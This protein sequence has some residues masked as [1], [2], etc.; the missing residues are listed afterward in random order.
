MQKSAARLL[1]VCLIAS[2]LVLFGCAKPEQQPENRPESE[3][4]PEQLNPQLAAPQ[5]SPTEKI[6]QPPPKPEEVSEALKRVFNDVV[7][8]DT[9]RSP[10]FVAGD[11]NADGSEDLAIVVK[12]ADTEMAILAINDELANWLIREP[13][14]VI[15]ARALQDVR[16]NEIHSKPDPIRKGDEMIVIIPSSRERPGYS[17]RR[18]NSANTGRQNRADLLDR[19]AILLV[20]AGWGPG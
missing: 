6:K 15:V 9:G 2:L 11:F 7:N 16:A 18:C 5:P 3:P 14:K 1:L 19:L 13:K 4:S 17:Q 20:L 10:N 8:L 12:P